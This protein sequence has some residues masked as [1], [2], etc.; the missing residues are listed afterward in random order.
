M[1]GTWPEEAPQAPKGRHSVRLARR[2]SAESMLGVL[3]EHLFGRS[4]K[5]RSLQFAVAC[6]PDPGPLAPHRTEAELP[7]APNACELVASVAWVGCERLRLD[8]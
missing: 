5:G 2:I 3:L 4:L 6:S 7:S 1:L 8:T